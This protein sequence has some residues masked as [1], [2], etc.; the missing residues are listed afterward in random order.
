[1]AP[2]TL[3]GDRTPP[4]GTPVAVYVRI[5]RDMGGEGEGVEDQEGVCRKRC[6]RHGWTVSKVYVENDVSASTNTAKPRPQYDA[7]LAAIRAGEVRAVVAYSN[8]RLTRR[9][10]ELEGLIRLHAETGVYIATI[11]SG[12]DDLS[13]ADGR[14][15]ARIKASVDAAEAER[16]SE[17]AKARLAARR[18]KGQMPTGQLP[19]GYRYVEEWAEPD[20]HG[21]Q[22]R[23]L[24]VLIDEIAAK[25]IRDAVES[26]LAGASLT[27]ILRRWIAQDVKTRD[28]KRWTSI[29]TLKRCLSNPR[30]AGLITHEGVVVG[31]SENW[32]KI[33]D[34]ETHEAIAAVIW[35]ANGQ[36]VKS[37][38][39]LLPGFVVCGGTM[40]DGTICGHKMDAHV[41]GSNKGWPPS[42]RFVCRSITGGCGKVT[43]N[44]PW[45][46]AYVTEYVRQRILGE[47]QAQGIDSR[48]DDLAA[49][50]DKAIA[51]TNA[52]IGRL[53]DSVLDGTFTRE[54]AAGKVAP[55]RAELNRLKAQRAK[56]T[57][58]RVIEQDDVLAV[59]LSESDDAETIEK[60]RA[61]LRRYVA[62]VVVKPLPGKIGRRPIPLDSVE[63][64]P[65]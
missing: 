23:V 46:D 8:S 1:M 33:L 52:Q 40:P 34:R 31:E 30:L 15:V 28:G 63:V 26:V 64:L 19:F 48:A 18:D 22:R 12:D 36:G 55:L 47:Y 4:T 10:L 51:D 54:E 24:H 41:A 37:R 5:S 42:N 53:M 21:K 9:P 17:R 59:W 6:D 32:P 58:S 65:A 43:R 14:M 44:K 25:A 29:A 61:I 35:K 11:V 7:M 13:T 27:T 50:L 60:R 57:Q 2:R 62:Q 49:G 16:T 56:V 45:L 38:R 3:A 20:A 39:Y